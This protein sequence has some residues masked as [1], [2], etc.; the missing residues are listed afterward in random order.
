MPFSFIA[1]SRWKNSE[2]DRVFD[3]IYYDIWPQNRDEQGVKAKE[4]K[5]F[6]GLFSQPANGDVSWEI[7]ED[8]QTN[9]KTAILHLIDTHPQKSGL[10]G[11]LIF[12][13]ATYAVRAQ[14]KKC[15]IPMP[16]P[17]E[18]SF[19]IRMGFEYDHEFQERL[20]AIARENGDGLS[21]DDLNRRSPMIGN[22]ERIKLK[23]QISAAKRWHVQS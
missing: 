1:P 4:Y 14:C 9:N 19:Y 20:Q 18:H 15:Q 6:G 22:P 12:I 2:N 3:F 10:G 13:F 11:F 21:P 7:I 23:S 8:K 5:L 17:H 16:N